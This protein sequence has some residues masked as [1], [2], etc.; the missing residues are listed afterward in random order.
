ME[1][2]TDAQAGYCDLLFR[3]LSANPGLA[4]IYRTTDAWS[5]KPRSFGVYIYAIHM[6]GYPEQ[7]VSLVFT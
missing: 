6:L 7:I 2:A 5:G 3:T 4:E 1:F